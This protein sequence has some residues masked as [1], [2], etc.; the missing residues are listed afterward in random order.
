MDKTISYACGHRRIAL[1]TNESRSFLSPK[2]PIIFIAAMSRRRIVRR[3]TV[4][5][6]YGRAYPALRDRQ[7]FLTIPTSLGVTSNNPNEYLRKSFRYSIH[8][9]NRYR[10]ERKLDTG[11]FVRRHQS[12]LDYG[13]CWTSVESW[14]RWRVVFDKVTTITSPNN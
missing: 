14:R 11:F 6:R 4:L 12:I 13:L 3:R 1:V 10:L 2:R 9:R 8:G 7:L 5:D